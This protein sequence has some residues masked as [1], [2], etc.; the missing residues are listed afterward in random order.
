MGTVFIIYIG[1]MLTLV[2]SFIPLLN[3]NTITETTSARLQKASS[4]RV[5]HRS[6]NE[7]R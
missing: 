7:S 5:P 3:E 6:G 2:G 4:F 1:S